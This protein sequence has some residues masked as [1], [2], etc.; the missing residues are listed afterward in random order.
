MTRQDP[1]GKPL[2]LDAVLNRDYQ[3]A[4]PLEDIHALVAEVRALR[5]MRDAARDIH[6]PR[7]EQ[8]ADLTVQRTLC[9][10]CLAYWP[11]AT[12]KAVGMER[13][14]DDE[15]TEEEG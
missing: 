3:R 7:S 14:P 11:C 2:D 9:P 8:N 6:A 13:E 15:R 1:Q 10:E 12:A 5:A 4:D